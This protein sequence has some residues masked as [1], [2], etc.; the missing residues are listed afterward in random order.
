MLVKR[1][2]TMTDFLNEFF[3]I[4]QND[5]ILND[6]DNIFNIIENEN[7]YTIEVIVPGFNKD[8]INVNIDDDIITIKSNIENKDDKKY[9]KFSFEKSYQL[10]KDVNKDNITAEMNNGIL[11]VRIEKNIKNK[12]VK[13]IEIK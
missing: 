11:S 10:P 5:Y 8:E 2:K 7:D 3:D 1:D 4:H 12:V 13:S 6:N 9:Y